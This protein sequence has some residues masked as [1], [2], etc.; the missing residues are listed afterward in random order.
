MAMLSIKMLAEPVRTIAFGA[1][2]PAY[3]GIGTA[4]NHP[5]RV[6]FVQNLTDQLMMFS[7]DGVND[8]FPLPS[9]GYMILDITANKTEAGGFFFADDTR[10]YVRD[11]GILPTLGGIYLTVFYGSNNG[12]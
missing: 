6:I 9:G 11:L 7:F 4:F 5:V 10:M 3:M 1:I 12:Q 2:G 8:H